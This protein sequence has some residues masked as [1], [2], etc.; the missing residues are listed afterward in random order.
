MH[1]E[2]GEGRLGGAAIVERPR[3]QPP[4]QAQRRQIGADG[5]G[6]RKSAEHKCI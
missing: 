2:V 6:E 4:D 3:V 1:L 5:H